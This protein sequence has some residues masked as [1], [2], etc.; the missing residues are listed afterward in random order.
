M[1]LE[2][3]NNILQKLCTQVA[4]N[5]PCVRFWEDHDPLEPCGCILSKKHEWYCDECP[6][7][8]V[9]PNQYKEWSK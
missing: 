8:D 5:L 1:F 3:Q 7:Q 9:C 4:D 6:V 2:D